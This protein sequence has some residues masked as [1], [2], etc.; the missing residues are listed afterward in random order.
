MPFRSNLKFI[1]GTETGGSPWRCGGED[2]PAN[3]NENTTPQCP[4]CRV[5]TIW[6]QSRLERQNG[7]EKIV[8]YYYCPNCALVVQTEKPAKQGLRLVQG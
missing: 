6:Y 8:Q 5:A 4:N 7:S 2:E 1:H 3:T